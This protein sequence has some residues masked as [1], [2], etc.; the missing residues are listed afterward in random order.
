MLLCCREPSA[1]FKG[2]LAGLFR[3]PAGSWAAADQGPT[4]S[5]C[6]AADADWVPFVA[7]VLLM[8]GLQGR[9]VT[10]TSRM[11]QMLVGCIYN[12]MVP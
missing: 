4:S 11:F 5:C 8:F 3:F 7:E 12:G 6:A 9:P 2:L 1:C 10:G